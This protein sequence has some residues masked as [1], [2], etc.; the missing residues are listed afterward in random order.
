MTKSETKWPFYSVFKIFERDLGKSISQLVRST[1]PVFFSIISK[2]PTRRV[3]LVTLVLSF[4]ERLL[5]LLV[6]SLLC[7]AAAV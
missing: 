4:D 3:V 1:G 6:G 5:S 2:R 7:V